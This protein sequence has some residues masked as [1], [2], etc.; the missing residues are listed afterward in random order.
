MTPE[1]HIQALLEFFRSNNTLLLTSH[2]RPDGDAIGSV[3]AL[4]EI[5][6]QLGCEAHII[7]VDPIPFIYRTLPNIGRI[8]Q[9]PSAADIVS[10]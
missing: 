1:A 7:L 9:T 4:A 6:E 3:L 2:A 5:L 8:H 10:E